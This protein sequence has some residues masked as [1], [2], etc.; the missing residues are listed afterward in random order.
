M[1][2]NTSGLFWDAREMSPALSEKEKALRD[3]FVKEYLKDGNARG[4]CLR[5]GFLHSFADEYAKRFMQE[6]YVRAEIA[7]LQ[8]DVSWDDAEDD[9]VKLAMRTLRDVMHHGK[10]NERVAAASRML[11]V[12]GKDAPIKTKQE[13]T[14]RGGVMM[15]PAIASLAEW[16][17]QATRSQEELISVA[18]AEIG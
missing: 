18:Q 17:Q 15:V 6:G 11:S 1:D 10:P 4:A 8:F 14:H 16:E 7:R 2:A 3:L 9:D 13:V 12:R 5:I